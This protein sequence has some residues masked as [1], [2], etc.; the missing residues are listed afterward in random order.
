MRILGV[1]VLSAA[2][3][4]GCVTVKPIVGPDG[5]TEQLIACPEVEG[6]YQK[7][8]EIC[9]KYT[10]VNTSTSVSGSG[11]SAES[12]TQLLVKCQ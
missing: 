11:G 2:L 1:A 6:C 8:H 3:L 5:S 7:A 12:Q 10:I 4:G 9:G